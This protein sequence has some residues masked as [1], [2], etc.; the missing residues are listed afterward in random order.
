MECISCQSHEAFNRVVV[1]R[2]TGHSY[3]GYCKSCETEKFGELLDDSAWHQDNGCA[4]CDNSGKYKLHK[5]DCLIEK[6]GDTNAL[7]FLSRDGSIA[8]CSGHTRRLFSQPAVLPD[9]ESSEQKTV[10][11]LEV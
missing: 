8:L 2:L 1:N 6:D 11:K 7:E 4:F 5:L 9:A 10:P 3:G